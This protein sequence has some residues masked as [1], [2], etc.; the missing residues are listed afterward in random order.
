MAPEPRARVDGR[1]MARVKNTE[2]SLRSENLPFDI[3]VWYPPLAR[4][5]FPTVFL[6]M[7][8][9]EAE[10]IM[11][12]HDA[13]WRHAIP[14][15]GASDELVLEQMEMRLD[16]AL[17]APMFK[18]TGAFMRLCGRSPKDGEPLDPV[19]TWKSYERELARVVEEEGLPA[20][21]ANTKLNAVARVQ[22]LSV[23]TGADAMCL[24]LTSERVFSDLHDWIRY[25]EPE[26]VVLRQWN[27]NITLDYEFRCFVSNNRMTCISQYDTYTAYPHLPPLKDLIADRLI[28][29]WRALHRDVRLDTYCMDFAYF[30]KEDR[31]VMIEL[32]PFLPCT[33]P[34]LFNWVADKD[35]LEGRGRGAG[36]EGGAG[37]GSEGKGE[38]KSEGRDLESKSESKSKSESESKSKG[39]VAGDG[40]GGKVGRAHQNHGRVEFRV[41]T[42]SRFEPDQLAALVEVNWEDRWRERIKKDKREGHPYRKHFNG[43]KEQANK[44]KAAARNRNAGRGG[45]S[46]RRL[47]C[48]TIAALMAVLL[49]AVAAVTDLTSIDASVRAGADIMLGAVGAT[50]ARARIES[51]LGA[52][53]RYLQ[54]LFSTFDT[55]S[56]KWMVSGTYAALAV[57]LCMCAYVFYRYMKHKEG[58]DNQANLIMLKKRRQ[59]Q[60]Q[61]RLSSSLG[62]GRTLLFV[63]KFIAH[64]HTHT[65]THTH[66]RARAKTP[67]PPPPFTSHAAHHGS[68]YLVVKHARPPFA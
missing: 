5:T 8:V 33:G 17:A 30:P 61:G 4:H 48:E 10:A 60:R 31:A 13:S 58:A 37:Q 56:I 63:C 27:P 22:W 49:I 3:D 64:T 50:E 38:S 62:E 57:V 65:H 2:H 40:R 21:D 26:Q 20:G 23:R 9:R 53:M 7:N 54:T 45:R 67:F 16:A 59:Q 41:L 34:C 11:H 35:L 19:A 15:L 42:K 68:V 6:P 29:A 44:D 12:F 28:A 32:S 55:S 24:L 39:A 52:G 66:A 46:P 14:E 25:G 36:A 51:G 1:G 47:I 43:V 18:G